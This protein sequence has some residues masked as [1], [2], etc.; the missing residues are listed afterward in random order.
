MFYITLLSESFFCNTLSPSVFAVAPAGSAAHAEQLKMLW[1]VFS[2]LCIVKWSPLNWSPVEDLWERSLSTGP[3]LSSG[4]RSA[5]RFA[6]GSIP[7]RAFK[8]S[9]SFK[10][11]A[12][13]VGMWCNF[14]SFLARNVLIH[15]HFF[16]SS[17]YFTV[18]IFFF[19]CVDQEQSALSSVDP[20]ND[21]IITH[22]G[23]TDNS[24]GCLINFNWWRSVI[25]ALNAMVVH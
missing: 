1:P 16:P 5:R 2:L 6:W 18:C 4:Q 17:L 24:K 7:E 22:L 19:I 3:K 10:S 9:I 14:S 12:E 25:V 8:P 23:K 11:A 15:L 13:A 21:P 20:H